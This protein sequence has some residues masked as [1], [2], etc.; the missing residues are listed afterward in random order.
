MKKLFAI[1]SLMVLST[2]TFSVK[3]QLID[4]EGMPPYKLGVTVG[5]NIPDFSGSCLDQNEILMKYTPTVGFHIGANLMVDASTWIDN[6]FGRIELKYTQKGA[7]W[8]D[9]T[10]GSK[11]YHTLHYLELPI[12]YGYAWYINDVVSLMAEAGPYFAIGLGGSERKEI[13][14]NGK[15]NNVYIGEFSDY[16]HNRFDCGVGL[17][18]SAMLAK[19]YQVHVAYDFGFIN[20]SR[21]YLQN[22]NFSIGFTWFFEHMF[23]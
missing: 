1:I 7:D 18:L 22:R 19:Y 6:T 12:H 15:I 9:L 13:L 14:H 8:K 11:E 16:G 2:L 17:Q 21:D 23:E 4:L 20:V 5:M 10:G 3:A